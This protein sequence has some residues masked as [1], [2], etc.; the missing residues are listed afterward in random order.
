MWTSRRPAEYSSDQ[1]HGMHTEY[2]CADS[3]SKRKNGM[4]Q[5]LVAH[6]SR[7]GGSHVK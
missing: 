1:R 5:V 7:S 2:K 4:G 3:V 6:N